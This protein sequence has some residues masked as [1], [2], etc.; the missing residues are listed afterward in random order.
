[1]R[2]GGGWGGQMM[3][4]HTFCKEGGLNRLRT[5]SVAHQGEVQGCSSILHICV[6]RGRQSGE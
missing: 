6:Q 1:M 4:N 2:R 5:L 3:L